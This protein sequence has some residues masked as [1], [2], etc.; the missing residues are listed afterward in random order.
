MIFHPRPCIRARDVTESTPSG[1]RIRRPRVRFVREPSFPPSIQSPFS[2]PRTSTSP[3][4]SMKGSI[5]PYTHAQTTLSMPKKDD[6]ARMCD[7][8]CAFTSPVRATDTT[9]SLV[10]DH[11]KTC[12]NTGLGFSR[13]FCCFRNCIDVVDKDA[14]L[15]GAIHAEDGFV[16]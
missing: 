7:A 6:D 8:K 1:R 4:S 15:G 9:T 12:S 11:T 5:G 2:S 13:L 10:S 14:V 16:A 3:I